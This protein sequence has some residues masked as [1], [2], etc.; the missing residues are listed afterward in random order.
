MIL[1]VNKLM[2]SNWKCL[3]KLGWL[4][5]NR[6]DQNGGLNKE[7][8]EQ[9]LDIIDNETIKEIYDKGYRDGIHG[10]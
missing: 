8:L 10:E 7:E 1:K 4:F 3:N 9:L 5:F 6:E 2:D